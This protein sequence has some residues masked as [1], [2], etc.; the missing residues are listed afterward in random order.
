MRNE[1]V[2]GGEEGGEV[3]MK[4]SKACSD[5]MCCVGSEAWLLQDATRAQTDVFRIPASSRESKIQANRAM[6]SCVVTK[7]RKYNQKQL[8]IMVFSQQICHGIL[9]QTSCFPRLMMAKSRE[10]SNH[11]R[12]QFL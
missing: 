2:L 4:V 3:W 11:K 7:H 1:S 8:L 5:A 6:V 12:N 9:S 10:D